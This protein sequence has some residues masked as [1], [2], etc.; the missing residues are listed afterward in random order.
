M[1]KL[2]V[3]IVL[4]I[5]SIIM[6]FPILSLL[7]ASFKTHTLVFTGGI[8]PQH[9]TL[10]NYATIFSSNIPLLRWILNSISVS[11]IASLIVVVIDSLAAYSLAKLKFAGRNVIFYVI[12]SSLMIPP[13][14]T[15]IPMYLEFSSANL[16]NTYWVLVLPYSANAFGI[17]LLYQF[18][19]GIPDEL[20]DAAKVDGSSKFRT[21]ISIFVPLSTASLATLGLLTFMNVYNDFFWPL[22]STNS[23]GMRT[24][25]VGV[26]LTAIGQYTTNYAEL[27]AL[28]FC[29]I[30]PMLLAFIFAQRK[31]T[32]GIST[33]GFNL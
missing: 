11:I 18:Y 6:I 31:L 28:T 24:V 14:A 20:V 16:L 2:P 27:M 1:K 21:W 17:F 7:G 4:V 22:V 19:L 29:S 3:V 23:N 10:K 32:Q 26:A 9:P 5:G 13:I 8:I 25:T 15:L 12:V 33:T 30:I